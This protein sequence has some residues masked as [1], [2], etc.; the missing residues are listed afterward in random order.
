MVLKTD[1]VNQSRTSRLKETDVTTQA[2]QLSPG[3]FQQFVAQLR[4]RNVAG[5]Q[6]GHREIREGDHG[7]SY[8]RLFGPYLCGVTRVVITDPFIQKFFQARNVMELLETIVRFRRDG[9]EIFVHLITTQ[10]ELEYVGNQLAF[11][12]GIQAGAAA[13]GITFTWEFLPKDHIHDRT[14]VIDDKWLITLGRGL[15]IFQWYDVNNAFDFQNRLQIARKARGFHIHYVR[16]APA[17][18]SAR[19][20]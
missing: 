13:Q 14:I 9:G 12:T 11:L 5:P 15:D 3:F 4:N 10:S 18:A 6:P 16:I 17:K 7:I 20:N 1:T 19:L 2:I 8:D